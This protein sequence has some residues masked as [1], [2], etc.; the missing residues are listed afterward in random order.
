MYIMCLCWIFR[1]YDCCWF[2]HWL[3]RCAMCHCVRVLAHPK[4]ELLGLQLVQVQLH[5]W[6][7]HIFV[8]VHAKLHTYIYIYIYIYIHIWL[9]V[10]IVL[11]LLFCVSL[12]VCL[13]WTYLNDSWSS[14]NKRGGRKHTI[15][16]NWQEGKR[17]L[18]NVGV[19]QPIRKPCAQ[20]FRANCYARSISGTA[21]SR[22]LRR[23]RGKVRGILGALTNGC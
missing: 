16:C 2:T 13:V 22:M 8:L 21:D 1:C 9:Y 15:T 20:L 12:G 14:A 7:E 18:G 17:E 5:A 4:L 6:H 23:Q 10:C 3:F 19:L 11:L